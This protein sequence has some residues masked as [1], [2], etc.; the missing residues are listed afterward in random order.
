VRLIVSAEER[1]DDPVQPA[2]AAFLRAA[3]PVERWMDR[4]AGV[5]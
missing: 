5:R 1:A 4:A 2:M 3:G